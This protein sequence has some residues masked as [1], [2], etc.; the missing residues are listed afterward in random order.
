[1]HRDT[2]HVSS[3]D[4]SNTNLFFQETE[5]SYVVNSDTLSCV[6]CS[7][8]FQTKTE[9]NDHVVEHHGAPNE[10]SLTL[11][12]QNT[13]EGTTGCEGIQMDCQNLMSPIA[14]SYACFLCGQVFPNQGILTVHLHNNHSQVAR[15]QCEFCHHI[16]KT[17]LE[18]Y[19]HIASIHTVVKTIHCKFCD[20]TFGNMRDLNEHTATQTH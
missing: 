15:Y 1:M 2:S 13:H 20:L 6:L 14:S 18:L 12:P 8:V 19:M 7:K 3:L 4:S 10:T 16:F 5:A 11:L 17:S 9:L